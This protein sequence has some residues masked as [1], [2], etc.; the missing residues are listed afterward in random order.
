[1][2][3]YTRLLRYV[4]PYRWKLLVSFMATGA[5]SVCHSMVSGVAYIIFKGFEESGGSVV[6][7]NLPK[8]GFLQNLSF[9]VSLIPH[10]VFFAVLARGIFDYI[11]NY[12]MAS[13]G[14][15]AVNDVRRDLFKHLT[16]LS[17]DFYDQE[18]T[19][20]LISRIMGDVQGIENGITTVLLD[21][22]KQPLVIL[23]NI[24]LVFFW[25]GKVAV[26]AV[27]V[28]PVVAVPIIMLG[29]QM[30]KTSMKIA[31]TNADIMSMLQEIF[32]GIQVIK[33]YTMEA[34]QV[35]RFDK[36]LGRVLA[37][38]KRV[39]KITI[40]QRP[41][42][43]IMAGVGV[44]FA[45]AYGYRYLEP[46]RFVAFIASLFV[47]YEPVKK[48]SKVHITIQHAMACGQRIFE[49]IDRKP[50][51]QDRPGAVELKPPVK[52]IVFNQVSFAYRAERIV[53]NNINLHVKQGDVVALVGLSGAGKST[54]V[55]LILRFYDVSAGE[56]LINGRDIRDYTIQSLRQKIG[57]VTQDTVLFHES[58]A[59]NI[60]CGDPRA[61]LDDVQRAARAARAHEFIKQLPQGYETVIGER[62][63]T[64]SGGQCQRLSIARAFYQNAPILILDEATS[65]LDTESEKQIQEALESLFSGRTVFVIAHRLSTIKHADRIVVLENGKIVQTGTNDSLLSEGGIYKRLYDLQFHT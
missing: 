18:R 55:N 44:A 57:I 62:G 9:P 7:E 22:F 15:H 19:G 43:E 54:L 31:Q 5:Y 38:V 8:V 63:S 49:V 50:T 13:V 14:L 29:R 17:H 35:E 24:P 46:G 12:F 23:I 51:I 41:L 3:E 42:I 1:M 11:S 6:I 40:V 53:L 2:H 65:Q 64:L 16:G 45:I 27:I 33:A 39:L 56:L 47:L 34:R 25:G 58:I 60:A 26:F 28:F 30:R 48:I 32:S 36:N 37:F 61:R 21:L 59:S 52:E 4:K 20:D 10:L